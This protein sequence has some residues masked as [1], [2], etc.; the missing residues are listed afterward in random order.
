MRERERK[1]NSKTRQGGNTLCCSVSVLLIPIS[2]PTACSRSTPFVVPAKTNTSTLAC[3]SVP[4]LSRDVA[5]CISHSIV[6]FFPSEHALDAEVRFG[7]PRVHSI[8]AIG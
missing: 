7:K 3:L 4:F 5:L 8:G 1:R 2:Q 6:R